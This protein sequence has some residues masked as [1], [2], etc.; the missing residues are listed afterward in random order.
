MGYPQFGAVGVQQLFGD[1]LGGCA[2]AGVPLPGEEA[3][4]EPALTEQAQ[5]LVHFGGLL[6][7]DLDQVLNDVVAHGVGLLGRRGLVGA[8]G[9]VLWGLGN[10]HYFIVFDYNRPIV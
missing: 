7:V 9:G 6:S 10:F 5:L 4:G 8:L 1:H 3:L 2:T